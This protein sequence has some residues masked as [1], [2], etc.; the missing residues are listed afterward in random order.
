MAK[1]QPATPLP[2]VAEG[3]HVTNADPNTTMYIVVKR[4]SPRENAAYLAHAANAYPRLVESLAAIAG[5][6]GP[7]TYTP[8]GS[9]ARALLNE[10][11]EL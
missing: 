3:H 9:A 4:A 2:W 6:E 11:G 1:H 10:L 8:E 5:Q 7:G